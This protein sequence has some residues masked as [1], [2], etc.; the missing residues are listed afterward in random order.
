MSQKI[1]N[2]KYSIILKTREL[3]ISYNFNHV[4]DNIFSSCRPAQG[5]VILVSNSVSHSVTHT[6]LLDP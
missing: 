2:I 6:F 4:C 5:T 1:H 3:I